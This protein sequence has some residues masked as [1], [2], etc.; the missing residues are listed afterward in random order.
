MYIYIYMSCNI[1]E[2]LLTKVP[3]TFFDYLFLLFLRFLLEIS[4]YYMWDMGLLD[5]DPE[6][7]W[8]VN[9]FVLNTDSIVID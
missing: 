6:P 3:D 1:I 9:Y 8:E 7:P 4:S 2:L 5:S